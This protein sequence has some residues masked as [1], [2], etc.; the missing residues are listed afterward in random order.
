MFDEKAFRREIS[1]IGCL[2]LPDSPEDLDVLIGLIRKHLEPEKSER[3]ANAMGSERWSV[4][5]WS[6]IGVTGEASFL[7]VWM[8]DSPAANHAKTAVPMDRRAGIFR[9][10]QAAAMRWFDENADAVVGKIGPFKVRVRHVSPLFRR[11]FGITMG[12]IK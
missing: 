4:R 10:I 7:E 6:V 3:K 8:R 11:I 1:E 2:D 9:D 5:G 12:W